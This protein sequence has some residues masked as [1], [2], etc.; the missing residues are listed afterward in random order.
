MRPES[1]VE[2]VRKTDQQC[3]A[4]ELVIPQVSAKEDIIVNLFRNDTVQE[5]LK[6]HITDYHCRITE[7]HGFCVSNPQD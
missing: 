4:A 6:S 1:R 7:L 5:Y 2:K 3:W